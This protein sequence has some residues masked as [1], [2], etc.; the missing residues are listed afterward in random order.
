[1]PHGIQMR[2]GVHYYPNVCRAAKGEDSMPA[3]HHAARSEFIFCKHIGI[4]YLRKGVSTE[5]RIRS[6]I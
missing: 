4:R 5:L 6:T 1:M 3:R 2:A